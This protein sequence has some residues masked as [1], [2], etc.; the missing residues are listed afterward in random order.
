MSNNN[1][2]PKKEFFELQKLNYDNL[3]KAFWEA[4][5]VAWT[6]TKIFVPVVSGGLGF[7]IKEYS[8]LCED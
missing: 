2:D 5:N 4:H 3:H 1:G 8:D 6:I 7:F